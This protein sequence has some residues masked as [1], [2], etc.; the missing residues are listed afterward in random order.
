MDDNEVKHHH[1]SS[2]IE[3]ADRM[4]L[5]EHSL[6]QTSDARNLSISVQKKHDVIYGMAFADMAWCCCCYEVEQLSDDF[7]IRR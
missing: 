3:I 5:K 6:S 2:T 7:T 1:S 4:E